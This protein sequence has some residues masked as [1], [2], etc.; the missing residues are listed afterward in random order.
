MQVIDSKYSVRP[1]PLLVLILLALQAA[2]GQNTRQAVIPLKNWATPLYWQPSQAERTAPGRPTPQL[3]FSANQ[4][5]TDALTFVAIT[6]CRLVDTRGGVFNG[7]SPFSGPSLA[8]MTT[9]TFP[10]Q[11]TAEAST[12]EPAPCGTIPSI[13]QAYSF[14]LTVVPH[15][16]GAVDYV[17]MWPAGATQ[18]I[19]ATLDDP[20]GMI[21]SNAAIVPAGTPSGGISVFNAGPT[22]ADVIIDMNGFFTAPSDGTN[23]AIGSGSLANDTTGSNNTASGYGALQSNTEGSWNTASGSGALQANTTGANNTASGYGA[24]QSNT[25]GGY[26]TAIGEYALHANTIG[27]QN[28]ASGAYAL[29]ANTNGTQNTASG[30]AALALNTTGSYNTASGALALQNN[31]QGFF[32]TASGSGALQ[33]NTTGGNNTASGYLA[34][35]SN[36][37]FDNT[38]NGFY[39]LLLNTSGNDNTATGYYAL[40]NNTTGGNN[41]AI[42]YQAAQSVSGGNSNNIHIGS[43]GVS[44]DGAAAN[45]GVIRIGTVGTQTS[46]YVAGIYGGSPGTTN[47]P[48]CVDANGTLG[49][50]T[51]TATPSSRRFKDQISDMGESSNKLLQLR[52]VTFLYKPEYDDGSHALQYGLIAE[53]VAKLYPEMV[54]YDKEGQPSSVKYQSLT[55]M[56]LNELQKQHREIEEQLETIR[57]Q[58]DRI[59]QQESRLTAAEALLSVAVPGIAAR[60]ASA[61]APP[62]PAPDRK[63]R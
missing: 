38:A 18:P 41:I 63:E 2:T 4:V 57:L 36:N 60:T 62:S 20:Q 14:N 32:N 7:I 24:L 35:T 25:S 52:P 23:T 51:C 49:T 11:S 45:S 31:T 10:V 8:P 9:V 58:K 42:G 33:A 39:A 48:V 15:A 43:Q 37:G 50:A 61:N 40:E 21:V 56:L 22:T 27:A 12:T 53:E 26:N 13:A 6:P 54:G 3:Q 34:L 1:L 28:T 30:Q 55:P 19:V 59:A 17:S 46:A 47:L 44:T 29:E 16:S 5:S